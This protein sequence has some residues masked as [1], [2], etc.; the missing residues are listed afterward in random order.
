[1]PFQVDVAVSQEEPVAIFDKDPNVYSL[2]SISL[3]KG[4]PIL[5][6]LRVTIGPWK[7]RAINVIPWVLPPLINSWMLFIVQFA[8][9]T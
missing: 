4:T 2:L 8:M 5:R 7:C 9:M 3:P 6:N 1:M